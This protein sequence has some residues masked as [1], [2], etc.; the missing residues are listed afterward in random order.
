M[1]EYRAGVRVVLR[2]GADLDRRMDQVS[3]QVS[4]DV[5]LAF[6]RNIQNSDFEAAPRLWGMI[7]RIVRKRLARQAHFYIRH[8]HAP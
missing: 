2:G 1:Q 4:F 5:D 3:G 8:E 7:S 6:N